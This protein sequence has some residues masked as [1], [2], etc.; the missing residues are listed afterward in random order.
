MTLKNM[1]WASVRW[2][3]NVE[4]WNKLTLQLGAQFWYE[5]R[6]GGHYLGD[7]GVDRSMGDELQRKRVWTVFMW[8]RIFTS[9]WTFVN[10]TMCL[11][12]SHR[13]GNFM[14]DRASN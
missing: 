6:K 14:T 4:T 13:T 11:L 2:V 12:V 3:R 9:G 1:K 7:L 10:T 8:S 5:N